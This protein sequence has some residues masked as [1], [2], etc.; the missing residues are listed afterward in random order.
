LKRFKYE[1]KHQNK[2]ILYLIIK[3]EEILMKRKG[4]S[5]LIA[6]VLLIAFVVVVAAAVFTWGQGWIASLT[7]G[8]SESSNLQLA[9]INQGGLVIKDVCDPTPAGADDVRFVVSNTGTLP[10]AT[11]SVSSSK[12]VAPYTGCNALAAGQQI[13]SGTLALSNAPTGGDVI[14]SVFTMAVGGKTATCQG[15]SYTIPTA[16]LSDC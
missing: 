6:T 7:E 12:L 9:C 1:K 2:H 14:S 8:T 15:G 4:I 3:K 5:P 13:S 11:C 10:H 16:G